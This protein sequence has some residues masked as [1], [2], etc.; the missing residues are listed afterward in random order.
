VTASQIAELRQKLGLSQVQ[1]AQLLGVH[2][3]TVSKWERGLLAP[4][5]HQAALLES[6]GEAR[7]SNRDIGNEV[8]TLLLTAGVVVALF[9]LL[10]AAVGRPKK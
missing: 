8:A 9:A 4:T 2:P 10:E 7:K 5:P 3:L 1:L 6:F